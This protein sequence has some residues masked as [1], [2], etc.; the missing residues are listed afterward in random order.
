[1][2]ATDGVGAD[3]GAAPLPVVA[4]PSQRPCAGCTGQSRAAHAAGRLWG[5]APSGR[6]PVRCGWESREEAWG[7]PGCGA[8]K[9]S[10]S[11][12]P[13][14]MA[15]GPSVPTK[16]RAIRGPAAC[17]L[18][19]SCPFLL[20]RRHAGRVPPA[21]EESPRLVLGE[22]TG[23][24]LGARTTAPEP[25]QSRRLAETADR[26]SPAVERHAEST[27]PRGRRTSSPPPRPGANVRRSV[28]P[29]SR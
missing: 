14:A 2:G 28:R 18:A 13:R 26:V 17:T 6:S 22:E 11:S 1:M 5:T 7:A 20:V 25:V 8:E 27:G 16:I 9:P 10:S 21:D 29:S 15:R 3:A 24:L 12:P 4:A 19:A 23:L